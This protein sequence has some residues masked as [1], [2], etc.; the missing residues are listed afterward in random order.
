[1]QNGQ[2]ALVMAATN[3]KR[4]AT[5]LLLDMKADLECQDKVSWCGLTSSVAD[6]AVWW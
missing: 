3:G 4:V 2:T 6:R 1:M 5:R